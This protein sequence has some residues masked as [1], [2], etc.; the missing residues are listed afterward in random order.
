MTT[1][2]LLSMVL[3]ISCSSFGNDP[4]GEHLESIS[5]SPQFN[6]EKGK[7]VNR[8]Q[9]SVDKMRKRMSLWSSSKEYFFGSGD[10]VPKS[11]LPEIKPPDIEEFLKPTES[12]KFIWFGHSTILVNFENTII[13]LDPVLSGSASPF[14]FMV[15]R[16]QA[17]VLKVNELPQIDYV[18]ISH[19]HYDHLDMETIKYF[20]NKKTKFITPLG[21]TS[22]IKSWGVT[23]NR[24][25]EL[26]W[27]Q[28]VTMGNL[29]FICAPAQHF[30]GRSGMEGGKTLWGSWII[31]SKN[32]R[33]YFSGDSG[34]DTHFKEIGDKYGP[35]DV[36]FV[37]NGQYNEMWHEV[38]LLPKETA[39]AFLELKGKKLVPIHW[40][41][42]ELALHDW[43]EPV[44][45][46]EKYAKQYNI[47]LLTPKFGQLVSLEKENIFEKWWK[48]FVH[49]K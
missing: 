17:P 23:E 49:K 9:D 35:F 34:Y 11:K 22:H 27:W 48:E 46:S 1:V 42:F 28:G 33:L 38:H 39:Q 29:E 13:L 36:A 40:A 21:V 32:N 2:L 19:D 14:S 26:D 6:K 18:V 37:E 45:E 3:L 4:E 5:K 25:H 30:S 16:F 44:E 7:F 12:I 15:K 43:Y 20:Q 31:K 8:Q 10:R 24:L 47:D 41:M